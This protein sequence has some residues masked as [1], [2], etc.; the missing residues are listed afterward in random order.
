MNHTARACNAAA[1]LIADGYHARER[2]VGMSVGDV[3][4]LA[5]AELN[6]MHQM[7]AMGKQNKAP[8]RDIRAS[9]YV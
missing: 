8:A 5:G 2:Y 7:E 9:G 3:E 4:R 6:R 1:T